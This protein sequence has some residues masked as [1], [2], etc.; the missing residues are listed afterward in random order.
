MELKGKKVLV[1]GLAKSGVSAVRFLTQKGAVV[2][3]TD[4]RKEEELKGSLD[5]H[6]WTSLK[7]AP[8]KLALGGHPP[9]LFEAADLIV[10][11]PG[12]PI[13]LPVI[14]KALKKKIPVWGEMEIASRFITIPMIAVTGTNGKSTTVTLMYEILKKGGKRVLL[15]GNIG[16]PLLDLVEPARNSDFVVV[17]VS[18]FQLET[19]QAFH[20]KIAVL[21]NITEDHLDRYNRFANYVKAK[22]RL[23][24]NLDRSDLLIVN[25]GDKTCR[26]IARKTRAKKCLFSSGKKISGGLFLK[27]SEIQYPFGKNHE[28]YLVR[29]NHLAGLHNKEN[30]MASIAVGRTL[31]VSTE[32]IQ[33][34]LDTFL[35]LPH[36]T[37]FVR[38]VGGVTYYNDSKATNVNATRMALAGFPDKKVLLIA[39]G[40]DK[41]FN[42]KPLAPF[43]RKKVKRLYLIGEAAEKI[44]RNIGSAAPSVVAETLEKALYLVSGDASWGDSVLLSPACASYDQFRNYEHRGEIFKNLVMRL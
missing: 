6:S 18:S 21:L 19:I 30:M 41:G 13:D 28:N 26:A 39:G 1:V 7:S 23:V 34:T 36:R 24:Q 14:Q 37:E 27:D 11:S 20:P 43:L 40:R 25:A 38:E 22:A 2:T 12:V 3:G 9:K 35:G 32:S 44:R 33:M 42:Y 10:P 15:G 5:A 31:G 16:T 29:N 8:V 4:L 17:E